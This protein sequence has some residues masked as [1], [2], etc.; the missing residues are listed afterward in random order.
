MHGA[1]RLIGLAVLAFV[2][3]SSAHAKPGYTHGVANGALVAAA[4]A[5]PLKLIDYDQELCRNGRTVA[6]WL[7]ELTA[8]DARRIEWS[9]GPCQLTDTFNGLD[10]GSQ[11]CAQASIVL[12]HPKDRHDRP[13]I[14]IYFDTPHKGRPSPAYA[15]RAITP[16]SGLLRFRADF[17]QDWLERFPANADKINCPDAG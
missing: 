13:M 1:G 4:K 2:V 6:E 15:F 7:A 3:A 10:G 5:T 11:W 16:E 12:K 17:E 9:G 8:G 14:E